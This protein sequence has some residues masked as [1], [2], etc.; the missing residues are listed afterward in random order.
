M[1]QAASPSSYI[2]SKS[3]INGIRICSF[4]PTQQDNG[5]SG[6]FFFFYYISSGS[7]YNR[8][9][10]AFGTAVLLPVFKLFL[11]FRDRKSDLVAEAGIEPASGGYEPPEV[12][13]LYSAIGI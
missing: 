2:H 4:L 5:A 1:R 10:G 13:L 9:D 12:P 8:T 6:H 7:E 11:D 3:S